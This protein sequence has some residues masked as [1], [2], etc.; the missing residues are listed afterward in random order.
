M[1]PTARSALLTGPADTSPPFSALAPLRHACAACGHCCQGHRV[2]LLDQAEVDKV[3]V[4]AAALGIADPIVDGAL[5]VEGGSCVFLDDARLCRI[6]KTFGLREKPRVCQQYPLRSILTEEGPRIGIDPGCSN[7]WRTWRTGPAADATPLVPSHD[8]RR[9]DPGPEA[10][11]IA[12]ASVPGLRLSSFLGQLVG[13]HRP[14]GP[15][16]PSGDELPAGLAERLAQRLRA[17]NL[18]RLLAFDDLGAGIRESLAHLVP[19]IAAL[20][21]ASPPRWAGVLEPESD[22]FALEVIRRH[23]F[24]RTG[25]EPLP[26][27]GQVIVLAAGAIACGWADPRPEVFGPAMS[28]WAKAMRHRAFWAALVPRPETLTW[29]A[30][31]T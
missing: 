21:P 13:G 17:M 16:N 11:L 23:L 30:T 3:L 22:A 5:R 26:E 25:D 4:Q 20:D 6:H 29:L 8:K 12:L 28:S 24:L 14:T 9:D 1:D 19:M 7:N 10:P 31:G 27:V 15:A 18:P 2:R